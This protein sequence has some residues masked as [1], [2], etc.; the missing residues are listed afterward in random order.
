M[1]ASILYMHGFASCGAGNKVEVLQQQFGEAEVLSPHL[2][3]EPEQAIALLEAL[4]SEHDIRLLVGSSLGGYYAEYLQSRHAIP[5]VLVNPSTRPFITLE[6]YIG[7]NKNWCTDENFEWKAEYIAQLKTIYREHPGN[8]E[9]YLVL[10]QTDDEVLDYTLASKRYEA[11]EVVIEEGG[12]HRFENLA[13]Y[14]QRMDG[15]LNGESIV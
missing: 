7:T 9:R 2:P 14:T 5:A 4:I 13:D 12:N 10:L 6:Q 8:D 1:S 15:F 11:F 3:V